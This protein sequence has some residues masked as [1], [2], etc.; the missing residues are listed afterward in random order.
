[1]PQVIWAEVGLPA[2]FDLALVAMRGPFVQ[3]G[4]RA[5]TVKRCNDKG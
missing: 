1:M 3:G 4:T 5:P 2:L